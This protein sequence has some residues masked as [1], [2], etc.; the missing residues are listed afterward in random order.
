MRDAPLD[1]AALANTSSARSTLRTSAKT[2]G[3]NSSV[4]QTRIDFTQQ[5]TNTLERAAADLTLADL[6][7]ESAN[8]LAIQTQQQL[9][10]NSLS[11]AANSQQ[12]V[13]SLIG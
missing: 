8:R 3:S 9:G 11:L 2:L 1:D 7:E 12:A 5:L 10:T 6:T 4:L 13:L